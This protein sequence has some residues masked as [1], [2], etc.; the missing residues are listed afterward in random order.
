MKKHRKI[1]WNEIKNKYVF[2]FAKDGKLQFPSQQDLSIEYTIDS[3]LLGRHCSKEGWVSLRKQFIS[4]RSEKTQQKLIEAVSEDLS[5]FNVNLFKQTELVRKTL[6]KL[7]ENIQNPSQAL[8]IANTLKT[9]KAIEQ[10]IIG[11]GENKSTDFQII[12]SS[13]ETKE[14]TEKVLN[15]ENSATEIRQKFDRNST[16]K[17]QRSK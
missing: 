8:I 2:G 16:G 6:D 3:G 5:E 10:D 13:E 9:L 4:E 15:G 12:V 11:V 17:E 1:D 14:L 7:I